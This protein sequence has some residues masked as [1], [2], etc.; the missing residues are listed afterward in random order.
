MLDNYIRKAINFKKLLFGD[1]SVLILNFPLLASDPYRRFLLPIVEAE[2]SKIAEIFRTG[3][4]GNMSKS[5]NPSKHKDDIIH[6]SY[7]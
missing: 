7:D 2:R 4:K 1:K 6:K 5:V 3:T